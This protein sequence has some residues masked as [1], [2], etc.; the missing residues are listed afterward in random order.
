LTD[1]TATVAERQDVERATG[2]GG[3]ERFMTI[4]AAAELV[5]LNAYE[6]RRRLD[7][8]PEVLAGE[9][10][11]SRRGSDLVQVERAWAGRPGR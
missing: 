10:R 5:G 11:L 6:L 1:G 7:M 4:A 9:M 2:V 3:G 8:E